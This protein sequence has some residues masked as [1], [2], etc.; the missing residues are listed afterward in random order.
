[1]NGG[2]L[3][4]QSRGFFRDASGKSC[5]LTEARAAWRSLAHGGD[6]KETWA[7]RHRPDWDGG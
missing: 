2:R 5:G 3:S 6:G 7:L 4:H 1:V